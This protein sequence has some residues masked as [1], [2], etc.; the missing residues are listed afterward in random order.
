MRCCRH[1]KV[2]Q[3]QEEKADRCRQAVPLANP[4]AAGGAFLMD[5]SLM[6]FSWIS[7]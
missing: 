6:D 2:P 4:T 5:F 3:N 1:G 7:S